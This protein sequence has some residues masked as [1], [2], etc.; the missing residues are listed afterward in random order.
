MTNIRISSEFLLFSVRR[1]ATRYGILRRPLRASSRT[2]I[3]MVSLT[4]RTQLLAHILEK[5]LIIC[6]LKKKEYAMYGLLEAF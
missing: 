6:A 1:S 2:R 3:R 5:S 4:S